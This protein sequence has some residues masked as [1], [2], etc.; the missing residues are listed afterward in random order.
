MDSQPSVEG[1]DLVRH[2]DMSMQIRV[3]GPAVPMDKGGGD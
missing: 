3:A 2:R 1:L